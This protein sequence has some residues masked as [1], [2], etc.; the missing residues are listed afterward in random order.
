MQSQICHSACSCHLPKTVM[1]TVSRLYLRG[2]EFY[3]YLLLLEDEPHERTGWKTQ[4]ALPLLYFVCFE[5]LVA[6]VPAAE[7]GVAVFAWQTEQVGTD[8][9]VVVDPTNWTHKK[10]L[11]YFILCWLLTVQ[12]VPFVVQLG[13]LLQRQVTPRVVWFCF[14]SPVVSSLVAMGEGMVSP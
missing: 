9:Q 3:T 1:W 10:S 7:L 2:K 4:Q 8:E 13:T 11:F 5:G 12:V 14:A 6:E